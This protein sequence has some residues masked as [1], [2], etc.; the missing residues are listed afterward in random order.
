MELQERKR[1]K[2]TV[3]SFKATGKC[4]S[5][6]TSE[7]YAT[8]EELDG[9]ELQRMIREGDRS[10]WDYSGLSKG[11]S[12]NFYFV[13][14]VEYPGDTNRYCHFLLDRVYHDQPA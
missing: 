12:G 1:A 5:S 7:L 2:I 8:H 11:F 14:D 3:T 4:Y 13:I 6:Y 10:V 9:F